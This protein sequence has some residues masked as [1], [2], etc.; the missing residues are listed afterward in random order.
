V[1]RQTGAVDRGT[2][3]RWVSAELAQL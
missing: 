1:A 3:D 2:L